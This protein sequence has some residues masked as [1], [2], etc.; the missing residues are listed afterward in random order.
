[1][2]KKEK[3]TSHF[4][5][6]SEA[7][8][9]NILK[10][11]FET[12]GFVH[13]QIDSFN[14]FLNEGLQNILKGEPPIVISSKN[15]DSN[16][17]GGYKKYTIIFSNPSV[18][19]PTIIEEDRKLRGFTPIEARRRNLNYDSPI[20]VTVETKL[21]YH[22]QPPEFF[23]QERVV[24]GRLPIMLRS[25]KCYLTN[26]TLKERIKAGECEKRWRRLLYY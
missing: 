18:P 2:K 21:E 23:K 11:H 1:M 8:R 17:A 16:I 20:Y 7:H 6:L 19:K 5:M 26:M 4:K 24:L 15:K 14:H 22:D 9:W 10:S 25:S 13:H 12:K 3:N